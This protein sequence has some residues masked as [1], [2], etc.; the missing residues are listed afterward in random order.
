MSRTMI[1]SLSMNKFLSR[2]TSALGS[3]ELAYKMLKI[4]EQ[5][6]FC[7]G[8]LKGNWDEYFKSESDFH[9]FFVK[10]H[11][12]ELKDIEFLDFFVRENLDCIFQKEL[13]VSQGTC[14]VFLNEE[15]EFY[16][17]C[18]LFVKSGECYQVNTKEARI[19]IIFS[20]LDEKSSRL[21]P[22]VKSYLA[23]KNHNNF[24]A[25]MCEVIKF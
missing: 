4:Y 11:F 12:I 21:Y 8:M 2:L 13:E 5:Y 14:D 9:E 22:F 10:Y 1:L 16:V 7:L 15:S 25:N 19:D 20:S 17:D 24:P 18:G 3:Q 6:L 23:V